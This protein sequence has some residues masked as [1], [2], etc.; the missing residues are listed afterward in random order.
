MRSAK[1]WQFLRNAAT[2]PS[3][4]AVTHAL[5]SGLR[6]EARRGGEYVPLGLGAYMM[7]G[8]EFS[9]FASSEANPYPQGVIAARK[10]LRYYFV[11]T[12]GGGGAAHLMPA[13][14]LEDIVNEATME[15]IANM[16]AK[17]KVVGS[18][19]TIQRSAIELRKNQTYSGTGASGV[20]IAIDEAKVVLGCVGAGRIYSV[21]VDSWKQIT[22]DETLGR[23]MQR[24][25]IAGQALPADDSLECL[26]RVLMH[27]F[28]P[29]SPKVSWQIIELPNEGACT[30]FMCTNIVHE[31]LPEA[32]LKSWVTSSAKEVDLSSVAQRL[33]IRAQEWLSRP[34]GKT[35]DLAEFRR[36][37]AVALLRLNR[38]S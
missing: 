17:E 29:E 13:R 22:E 36:S 21:G 7:T 4:Y 12:G 15:I 2:N 32:L 18:F 38:S 11:G 27:C 3:C 16:S 10:H 30:Y 34:G 33:W 19:D 25:R 23:E 31:A 1:P 28:G 9:G 37:G 35:F 6:A 20:A 14:I 26:S 24:A 8:I 5:R